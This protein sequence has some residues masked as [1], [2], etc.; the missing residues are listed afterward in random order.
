VGNPSNFERIRVLYGDDRAGLGSDVVGSVHTD[1]ETRRCI[2]EVFD[3]TGY[4]LD[5]HS[6]VAYLGMEAGRRRWPQ[7]TPIVLA[8]AHPAKFR[9]VV[10]LEIGTEVSVPARLAERLDAEPFVERLSA[11]PAALQEFLL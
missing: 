5:P 8:T 2:A 6:A 7:S 10:E 4:V 3:R 11:E 9:E 1:S